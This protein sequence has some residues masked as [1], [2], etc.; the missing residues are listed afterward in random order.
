M[1]SARTGIANLPLHGGTA[2]AWLFRRMV[3]LARE[4]TRCVV[5]D[6]G[7]EE[8]LRRLSDPF[9]FQAFGCVLGF[10]WRSSGLTTTT[11]GAQLMRRRLRHRRAG[12]RSTN[13]A[14]LTGCSVRRFAPPL[15]R[16]VRL[17]KSIRS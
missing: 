1:D 4:I 15:N 8:M 9:W 12:K 7:P 13:R 16:S 6:Y 5:E 3:A 17:T 2:P 10:D 11:C 14:G